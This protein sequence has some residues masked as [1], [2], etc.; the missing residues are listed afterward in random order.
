MTIAAYRPAEGPGIVVSKIFLMPATESSTVKRKSTAMPFTFKQFCIR[1]NTYIDHVY[2]TGK[3]A[4]RCWNNTHRGLLSKKL[5]DQH[6][7][8]KRRCRYFEDFEKTK[9]RVTHDN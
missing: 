3:P 6:K 8:K 5:I 7:C 1:P 9:E 4:G 2:R